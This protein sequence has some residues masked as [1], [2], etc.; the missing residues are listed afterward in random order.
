MARIN[1]FDPFGK[2]RA[3]DFIQKYGEWIFLILLVVLFISLARIIFEKIWGN[4]KPTKMVSIA[5]GLLMA[6][7][8][9]AAKDYVFLGLAQF[10]I[11]AFFIT[12]ILL[13]FFI[14]IVLKSLF[15][16]KGGA[17]FGSF[18]I[19]Y[20]AMTIISPSI[21]D[22]FEEY[23]PLL[24]GIMA[25]GFIVALIYF[26]IFGKNKFKQHIGELNDFHPEREMR[27]IEPPDHEEL[28]REEKFEEKE[29]KFIKH[30][31]LRLLG[32]EISTVHD[33]ERVMR[34]L[35]HTLKDH[36]SLSPDDKII[37]QNLFKK[38]DDKE[39]S[40]RD[41][42]SNFYQMTL[43]MQRLDRDEL[44]RIRQRGIQEQDP[45]KKEHIKKEYL[46]E[47]R[48][49]K[50]IEFMKEHA[51]TIANFLSHFNETIT[52]CI[53]SIKVGDSI[54]AYHKVASAHNYLL[55]VIHY[56]EE[57]KDHEKFIM[58]LSEKEKQEI[59]SEEKGK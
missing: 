14:Y 29:Y 10:G 26:V 9:V 45:K 21:T 22:T 50:A 12:F 28:I 31:P 18:V 37:L 33:L 58:K 53:N 3:F 57:M 48:K 20:L 51:D 24:N 16:N 41:S 54:S 4:S 17:F 34:E 36:Q 13:G 1:V 59:K 27:S 35:A 11:A 55:N 8:L 19:T 25:V 23:F 32:K 15:K 46:L 44:N 49:L 6:F 30:N 52:M 40:L 47:E 39:K 56:L 5:I 43:K 42:L 7:G 38:L 2:I